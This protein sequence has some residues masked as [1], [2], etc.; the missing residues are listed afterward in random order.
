MKIKT[1]KILV[2]LIT[3]I[4]A[5]MPVM[6]VMANPPTNAELLEQL[7][8]AERVNTALQQQVWQLQQQLNETGTEPT[9]TRPPDEPRLHIFSPQ[10]ITV[11]PG[12]TTEVELILRN[13]GT[14]S[15]QG[16]MSQATPS[17]PFTIEFL[18]NSN[19]TNNIN[20]GRQHTIRMRISV[21]DNVPSGN[22]SIAFTH[23][24]RPQN[25]A[26]RTT[27]DTLSVRIAGDD[28]TSNLTIRNMTAPTGQIDVGQTASISFDVHNSGSREARNVRIEASPQVPA[29][30]VPVL[31]ANI[32][33]IPVIPPGE[34]RRVT[35]N[36]SPR[37]AAETRSYAIGF[38]VRHAE[39]SFE[40]FASIN[41]NNPNQ[42]DIANI[43]IRGMTAPTGNL[44]V[45]QT[46]TVSFYVHNNGDTE[47]RNIR[48]VAAPE[49]SAIRSVQT[50]NSQTI[51]SL[52]PGES[53][54]LSFSF[55]PQRSATTGSYAIGFTVTYGSESIQQF[56]AL[57]VYNPDEDADGRVQIP[58]VIVANTVLYPPMPRAGQPFEMEVTFRNTSATR[59]VNNI[60]VLMEEV[61]AHTPGQQQ[62]THWAGFNPLDGSNTIFID[63]LAPQGET[64]MTLRFTTVVEA[65][66]GAHNMRFTFDYQDQDFVTHTANQQISIS[67]AQVSRLELSDV[68]VGGW[69]TPMV[70]MQVP[71]NFRI[72]NSGR[73]NVMSIRVHTEGPFDVADAGGTD[74]IFVGQIN[75][76]RTTGFDG[77]IV[78]LYPGEQSGYFIVS[79]EDITGQ[80]VE[81]RHPFTIFV[82]GGFEGGEWGEG[83]GFMPGRPGMDMGRPGIDMGGPGMAMGEAWCQVSGEMVQTGYICEETGMWVDL[84]EWCPQTGAWLPFSTGFDFIAFISRPV[85]WGSAIGV[86]VIGIIVAVVIITRKKKSRFDFDDDDM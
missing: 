55:A 18:N 76:Q 4:L 45:G 15:A 27:T 38:T 3:L 12:E 69:V 73:V 83:G 57:N 77:V 52:N 50:S 54:R 44:N 11:R 10:N 34:S 47:A 66:P 8:E 26:S 86:G 62:Q 81:I 2:G 36:F 72:I 37:D 84:G 63:N 28:E 43:E 71:F 61:I 75:F 64:T 51:T 58:R 59:S 16:I 5:L 23:H 49:S 67:L 40:Q 80:I 79:G 33:S 82:E 13:V 48:V 6:P 68:S 56:T 7:L 35:F 30:I 70:G 85:V 29:A 60:R 39:D 46:G 21:N 25:Q 24:F 74:G 42:D 20:E 1:K 53:R 19:L 14:G 17:G 31:T 9:T 78:P 41:V 32:Q 22:H 65:T